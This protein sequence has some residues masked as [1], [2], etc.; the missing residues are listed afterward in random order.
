MTR[1]QLKEIFRLEDIADPSHEDM[2]SIFALYKTFINPDLLLYKKDCECSNS[3][4]NLY[5]QLMSWFDG[6]IKDNIK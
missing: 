3:I 1:E 2:E 5:R 6:Y 4:T